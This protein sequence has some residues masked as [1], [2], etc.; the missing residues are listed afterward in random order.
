MQGAVSAR[1][2][3]V[4]G[5]LLL[6]SCGGDATPNIGLTQAGTGGGAS[7]QAPA[8]TFTQVYQML[9]PRTTN[10]HCDMC[11]GLPPFDQSNGN[12]TTG[13][14]RA[15]TR[16][17][18]VGKA[19]GSSMCSGRV[20]VVPGQPESSLLLQKVRPNPPCGLRMPIG[21]ATLTDA[22]VEL[23]RSWIAAGALDD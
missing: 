21:G 22:Q 5:G 6:G 7:L 10:A 17:A 12:L 4:L 8:A 14:D 19:S 9:F 3:L 20:L 16:A 1:T 13:M 23:I 15:S 18:L 11:H 2:L